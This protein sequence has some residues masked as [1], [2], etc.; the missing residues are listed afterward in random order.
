MRIVFIF[1]N[2]VTSAVSAN[3]DEPPRLYVRTV[4]R[5]EGDSYFL[6]TDGVWETMSTGELERCLSFPFPGAARGLLETLL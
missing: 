3:S 1:K 2:I 4:S 6:C 5:V